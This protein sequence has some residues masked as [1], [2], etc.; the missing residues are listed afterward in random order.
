[1]ISAKKLGQCWD[2]C[3]AWIFFRAGKDEMD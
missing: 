3:G 2:K 1:L